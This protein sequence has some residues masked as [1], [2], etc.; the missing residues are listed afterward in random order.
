VNRERSTHEHEATRHQ[1]MNVRA[2]CLNDACVWR[3][4]LQKWLVQC[5]PYRGVRVSL[6][7]CLRPHVTYLLQ[8]ARAVCSRQSTASRYNLHFRISCSYSQ[9]R[10]QRVRRAECRIPVSGY[11]ALVWGTKQGDVWGEV[12]SALIRAFDWPAGPPAD[13]VRTQHQRRVRAPRKSLA[14][15]KI[16]CRP[17]K[18][19]A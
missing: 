9:L 7:S 16:A 13:A 17:E 15:Q 14:L 3:A 5:R 10:L 1:P 2:A 11:R 4:R 18:G 19:N 8:H 6:R 12:S